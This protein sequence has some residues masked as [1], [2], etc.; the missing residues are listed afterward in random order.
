M[1]PGNSDYDR[2]LKWCGDNLEY[3]SRLAWDRPSQAAAHYTKNPG[4]WHLDKQEIARLKGMERA[5]KGMAYKVD[6]DVGTE[7]A[8]LVDRIASMFREGRT[9]EQIAQD[10]GF[11]LNCIRRVLVTEGLARRG[12]WPPDD[13][14]VESFLSEPPR[15]I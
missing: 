5:A 11:R 9:P 6:H 10:T 3:L 15:R 14:Q 2:M 1:E 7:I 8:A 12:D 4:T 13:D